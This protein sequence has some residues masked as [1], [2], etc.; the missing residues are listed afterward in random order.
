MKY[1]ILL[2]LLL[3]STFVFASDWPKAKGWVN[4]YANKISKSA[5]NE[6]TDWITDLKEETSCEIAIAVVKDLDGFGIDQ[7]ANRLF[8]EWKVG[9]KN[10]EGAL[11]VVA[12]IERKSRIEV[13]YG[14]EGYITDGI[15][16][17][18]LR[19][20]N[21]YLKHGYYEKGI[22]VAT[23][24]LVQ[25]FADEYAVTIDGSSEY[26]KRHSPARTNKKRSRRS[27]RSLFKIIIVVILIIA[28]RGRIIPYL[29]FGG[30]SRGHRGGGF[31]GFGGFG[32][33]SGSGF[34]GGGFGGFGGFGGGSSGGGGA[35]GS[36]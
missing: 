16:G 35:S 22:K 31:G 11:I 33:S 9:N 14:A 7:Y 20:M 6:L 1:K 13:G 27:R 28:T 24:M 21:E 23:A 26:F 30:S 10:S 2:I 15:A 5:E 19:E 29:L 8:A 18:I 32:G 3:I 25:R 4:D 17:D 12:P 34:G 36:F